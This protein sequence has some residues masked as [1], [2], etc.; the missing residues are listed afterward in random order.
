MKTQTLL[1]IAITAL[2]L[3]A[4]GSGG[5]G[6]PINLSGDDSQNSKYN[7]SALAGKVNK[8]IRVCK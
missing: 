2:G 5:G 6:S 1:A 7:R 4:C 3:A 8:L